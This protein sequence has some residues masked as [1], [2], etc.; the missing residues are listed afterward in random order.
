[1]KIKD[2]AAV[3]RSLV[4]SLQELLEEQGMEM[5]EVH[6]GT[7]LGADLGLASVD[8]IH[9]LIALEDRLERPL[10]FD[11][12]ATEDDEYRTDI[13][14]GELWAFVCQ[15]VGVAPPDPEPSTRQVS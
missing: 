8:A 13:S 2:A 12:L 7:L 6:S 15:K 9:L 11:E 3:R 10:S 1:M 4:D 14:F 5:G